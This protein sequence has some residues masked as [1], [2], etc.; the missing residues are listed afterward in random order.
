M[1]YIYNIRFIGSV[2][3]K[4]WPLT[5]YEDIKYINITRYLCI[6]YVQYVSVFI[7]L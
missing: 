4:M 3:T 5:Y 1:W 2:T 7:I 6:D